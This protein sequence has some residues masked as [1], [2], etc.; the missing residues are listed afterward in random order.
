M[1][2]L[3]AIWLCIITLLGCSDRESV[4][5]VGTKTNDGYFFDAL[6]CS[7]SSMLHQ[8]VKVPTA[9]SFSVVEVPLGCDANAFI[10][11]MAHAG[12]PVACADPTEYINVSKACLQEA[13]G[14]TNQDDAYSLCIK[15]SRIKVDVLDE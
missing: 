3:S 6:Q 14:A 5:F 2:R 7:Q 10:A 12:R 4:K 11:C 13:R 8:S 1:I 15:R 9:G